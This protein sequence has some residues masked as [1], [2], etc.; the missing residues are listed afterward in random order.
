MVKILEM[1]RECFPGKLVSTSARRNA[2]AKGDGKQ[3]KLR[4][5]LFHREKRPAPERNT[6]DASEWTFANHRCVM[7]KH[8]GF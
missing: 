8:F 7:G 2:T 5:K 4:W 3:V 1:G 6:I